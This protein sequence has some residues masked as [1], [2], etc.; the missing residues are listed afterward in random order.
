MQGWMQDLP[1]LGVECQSIIWSMFPREL[2][3]YE[4][5][6]PKGGCTCLAPLGSAT[7]LN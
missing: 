1:A 5:I 2:Q 7:E 6:G 4:K 3:E